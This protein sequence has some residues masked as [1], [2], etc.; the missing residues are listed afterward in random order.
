MADITA[1]IKLRLQAKPAVAAED[2]DKDSEPIPPS[3][4]AKRPK[5]APKP[6]KK[7]MKRPSALM[8]KPAAVWKPAHG[9]PACPE[10]GS[11][12]VLYK[13]AKIYISETRKSFRVIC[14]ATNYATEV[15]VKW[16][17]DKPNARSWAEALKK[18]DAYKP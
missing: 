14:E 7:A 4:K 8:K 16:K 12:P 5:A 1:Q 2:G 17:S 3:K 11:V 15:S 6:K 10:L 18:V 9:K 13:Q